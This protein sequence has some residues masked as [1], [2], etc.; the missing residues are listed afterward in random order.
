MIWDNTLRAVIPGYD[1]TSN[2]K[3]MG[4]GKRKFGMDHS[5]GMR[6]GSA[7]CVLV[8]YLG[9]ACVWGAGLTKQV[10][11]EVRHD[12]S[13]ERR[14]AGGGLESETGLGIKT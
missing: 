3:A 6:G 2:I 1:S 4:T 14:F 9:S 11:H 10:Q 5:L 13:L 8:L 7:W 12:N